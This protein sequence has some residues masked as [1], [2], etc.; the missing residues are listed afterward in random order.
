MTLKKSTGDKA[1]EGENMRDKGRINCIIK[2]KNPKR[3]SV[4][5]LMYLF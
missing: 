4:T 2:P 3:D 1:E 5:N